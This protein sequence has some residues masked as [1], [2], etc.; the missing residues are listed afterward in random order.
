MGADA[1]SLLRERLRRLRVRLPDHLIDALAEISTELPDDDA[2]L[3]D[4]LAEI[5]VEPTDPPADT[6]PGTRVRAPIEPRP[7]EG[8][9]A[10]FP[11]ENT[12]D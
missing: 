11:E 12:T 6:D 7:H 3:L 8:A 1:D 2:E 9:Q 10:A 5:G 4:L